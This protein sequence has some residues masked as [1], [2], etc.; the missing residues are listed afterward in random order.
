[1]TLRFYHWYVRCVRRAFFRG[2]DRVTGQSFEHRQQ[3]IVSRLKFLSYVYAID[4]YAYAVLSNHYHVVLVD[5][6]RAE[7]WCDDEVVERWEQLHRVF[8]PF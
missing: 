5:Q 3:W 2:E 7:G 6:G 8:R 1:M 4:I